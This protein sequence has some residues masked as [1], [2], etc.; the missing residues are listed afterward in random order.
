VHGV[1]RI[2]RAFTSLRCFRLS[3]M[4]RSLRD[5]GVVRRVLDMFWQRRL[6]EQTRCFRTSAATLCAPRCRQAAAQVGGRRSPATTTM[7]TTKSTGQCR[8]QQ[9][10]WQH[11]T[12]QPA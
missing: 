8:C 12:A 1:A 10:P 9:D 6:V 7:T 5:A 2:R 11:T 4:Q 3:R